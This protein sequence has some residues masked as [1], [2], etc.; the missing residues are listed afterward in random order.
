MSMRHRRVHKDARRLHMRHYRHKVERLMA[1]RLVDLECV[2]EPAVIV[3][4]IGDAAD[5][6]Y[7]DLLDAYR[8]VKT[9]HCPD[10]P[11][12]IATRQLE[13]LCAQAFF[14]VGV[15]MK[16]YV[17][18]RV[19]FATLENALLAIFSI[20]LLVLCPDTGARCIQHDVHALDEI[21]Q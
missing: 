8:T 16:E 21:F 13:K 4:R 12:G 20:E 3:A 6:R 5:N 17:G 19:F 11:C 15:A 1:R 9:I 10:K 2:R 7:G 18:Y 14:V